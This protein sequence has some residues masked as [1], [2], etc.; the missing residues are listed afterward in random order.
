MK[1]LL[2]SRS[3][4]AETLQ[5]FRQTFYRL[6]AFSAVINVLML[7]PSL[8]MMQV[9][10]RVLHS[11][12]ATTLLM[13][14]L[15]ILGLYGLMALLELARSSTLIRVGNRL[16]M[17]LNFRIFTAAFERN[18]RRS[19]GNAAQ[20]LHDLT[21]VRQFLTGNGLFA[22]FDAPWAP[23]YLAVCFMFHWVL[24]LFV[25]AGI[26]LLVILTY[27]TEKLTRQP[28]AE[29]NQAAIAAGNYANNNLRNAEVIEAMGMLPALRAR[30]FQFQGKVLSKQT[31][32]S[33]KAARI[34]AVT[35]F[36]R[37]SM[38]SLVLGVGAMLALENQI[39][40]GMMI[41]CSILM[42]RALQP[43]E[44][45]IGTWKQ[46]ISARAAYTR[47]EEL[48]KDF[49]ERGTGMSLP[50]PTGV[51]TVE[52]AVAVPPG[53]QA[54]VLK[55]LSFSF[56]N[57][58]IIGVVG[59]SA[60][61][62]STLARLLVGIWPTQA[63]KIRL[64]GA[65][66]FRWNKDELGPYIGYLPQDI[67]LFEGTIAENIARFGEV[68]SEKV[69]QA[70]QR[71]GVHEM[72]LR[73]PQGY[74]T[75]LGDGGNLLSGGQKQRIGLARAMYGDP[76]LIVLDEPNSNLDD[77]GEQALV[78]AI[79]DLKARGKTVVLITH[80]TSIISAV[81]KLM[82]LRDGLLQMYGP[83]DQVLAALA[84]ANQQAALQQQ[85]AQQAR[86]AASSTDEA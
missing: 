66:I 52:N 10:D 80:R 35:K 11:R 32:A 70:A 83:R 39:T 27:V 7:L 5:I 67:E 18:L 9:Y 28:L 1:S 44:M 8:Y 43:V 64:D 69:I 31:E 17:L 26:L 53:A 24:G 4:L 47:L 57:G 25:L 68:D 12:N 54:P 40:P 41:A 15:L 61:G 22:F 42:G 77:V 84:Q 21:S 63:G 73:F 49:P 13:L 45:A 71:A 74:D 78:R 14:T 75:R 3:E 60:S 20:A 37:L 82:V 58:E 16:D 50:P 59:P 85:Q 65:D 33:D 6:G 55:G 38:Q 62:K 51:V 81:D 86:A 30:W 76:S 23:I 2:Q 72:I 34:N 19:G 36:V 56:N 79:I 48:L 29:A 46:L